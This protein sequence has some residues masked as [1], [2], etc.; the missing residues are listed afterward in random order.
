MKNRSLKHSPSLVRKAEPAL[1]SSRGSDLPQ[2]AAGANVQ[3][4]MAPRASVGWK[5]FPPLCMLVISSSHQP[6]ALHTATRS[7]L[8]SLTCPRCNISPS[9]GPVPEMYLHVVVE[10]WWLWSSGGYGAVMVMERW[11]VWSVLTGSADVQ[12]D[13]LPPTIHTSY[14]RCRLDW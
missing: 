12:W 1:T 13:R 6:L 10:S 14:Q 9:P 7:L 5:L 4:E 11:W 3:S 8:L 2:A